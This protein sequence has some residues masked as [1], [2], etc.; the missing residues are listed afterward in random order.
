M[1][2]H[3]I[4]TREQDEAFKEVRDTVSDAVA[5]SMDEPA[6]DF[7]PQ[8]GY[9]LIIR[10]PDGYGIDVTFRTERAAGLLLQTLGDGFTTRRDCLK[11]VIDEVVERLKG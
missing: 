9:Q 2:P 7:P 8:P 5:F 6:P 10:T 11:E 1:D 3:D 4:V